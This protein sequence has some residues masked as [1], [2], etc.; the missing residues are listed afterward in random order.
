MHSEKCQTFY[1]SH[2]ISTTSS[3]SSHWYALNLT[4][5]HIH[6]LW[7]SFLGWMFDGYEQYAIVIAL[8][9]AL[10]ALLKPDELHRQSLYFGIILSVTLVG[11]GIGGLAGGILADYVGR[12]RMMMYSVLV[13]AAFSGFSALSQSFTMLAVFR[14]VTG[15]AIGSEWSTGVT[16]ITETWPD[17]ARAKGC[18]F[19]QSAIGAG[20][21]VAVS[22]WY[23]LAHFEI[24]MEVRIGEFSFYLGRCLLCLCCI[25]EKAWKNRIDGSS[26]SPKKNS[27][28]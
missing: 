22:F 26:L 18:G 23:G 25:Y 2:G 3:V 19:L 20:M 12:K 16:L 4:R 13:Y 14:F 10:Q 6:V 24:L 28:R 17:E 15:L 1:G 11:W 9:S 8:P 7:G 5:R 27:V 21:L